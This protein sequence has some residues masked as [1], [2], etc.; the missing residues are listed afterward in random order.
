MLS[1]DFDKKEFA[2]KFGYCIGKITDLAD[3]S[4][5]VKSQEYK[6]KTSGM[7][8]ALPAEDIYRL[9]KARGL[10]VTRKYDGEMAMV[11]FDGEKIISVNPCG[12][13]RVGLPCFDEAAELLKKAKVKS[14]IL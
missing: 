7:M 1:L 14:C 2:C 10:F 6:R 8:S 13:V 12:T 9:P 5:H 3:P 4:L 11:F